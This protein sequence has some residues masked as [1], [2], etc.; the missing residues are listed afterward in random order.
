MCKPLY[1]MLAL[2]VFEDVPNNDIAVI[3]PAASR[4]VES[5]IVYGTIFDIFDFSPSTP[6]SYDHGR[7]SA[8]ILSLVET[9]DK[10]LPCSGLCLSSQAALS[11][12]SSRFKTCLYQFVES[13]ISSLSIMFFVYPTSRFDVQKHYPE[14]LGFSALK[15]D[16]RCL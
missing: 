16:H 7:M 4:V 3:C 11:P 9:C 12:P 13:P 6:K 1:S 15:I 2:R 14:P 5:Y 8:G 10:L